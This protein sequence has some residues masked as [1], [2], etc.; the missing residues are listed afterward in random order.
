MR[1]LGIK[2]IFHD[3]SAALVADGQIVAAAEEE[4]FSRRMHGIRRE[5]FMAWEPE[6]TAPW[7]EFAG[8]DAGA[9]V[10][11]VRSLFALAWSRRPLAAFSVARVP[12][13][14]QAPCGLASHPAVLRPPSKDL[15]HG[16]LDAVACSYHPV[17]THTAAEFLLHD[18]RGHLR[19]TYARQASSFRRTHCTGAVLRSCTPPGRAAH[20]AAGGLLRRS[21]EAARQTALGRYSLARFLADGDRASEEGT[22]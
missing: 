18:P 7:C 4:C 17:P 3:A 2:A 13:V 12:P 6:R 8:L 21:G 1:V 15:G 9:P 11:R 5:P 16:T 10:S 19:R 14:R 22:R 20:A